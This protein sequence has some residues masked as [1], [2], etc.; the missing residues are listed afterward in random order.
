MEEMKEMGDFFTADNVSDIEENKSGSGSNSSISLLEEAGNT[1]E[2]EMIT[3]VIVD[4]EVI[5]PSL[6]MKKVVHGEKEKFQGNLHN[7]LHSNSTIS[8]DFS[9]Q[10]LETTPKD[11]RNTS[12]FQNESTLTKKVP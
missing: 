3:K 12:S 4:R 7:T 2:P 8:K 10:H 9:S 11:Y 1:F 5:I 6:N